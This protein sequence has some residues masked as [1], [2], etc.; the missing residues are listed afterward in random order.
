MGSVTTSWIFERT[1]ST[2]SGSSCSSCPFFS[3]FF[4]ISQIHI[5]YLYIFKFGLL[6]II[7]E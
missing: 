3:L 4:N 1:L 5:L 2:F 7:T 6:T